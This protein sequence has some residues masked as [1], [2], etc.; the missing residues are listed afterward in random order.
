VAIVVTK[1]IKYLRGCL[2]QNP[3]VSLWGKLVTTMAT[4]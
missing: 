2:T 3:Q 4:S 1:F